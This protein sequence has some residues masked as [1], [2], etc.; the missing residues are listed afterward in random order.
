VLRCTAPPLDLRSVIGAHDE[1]VSVACAAP[2]AGIF[3]TASSDGVIHTWD[4]AE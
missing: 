4:A 2:H 3:A 1:G